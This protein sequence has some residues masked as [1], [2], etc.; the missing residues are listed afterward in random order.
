VPEA[1]L[2]SQLYD[3]LV[4]DLVRPL[5]LLFLTAVSLLA[6]AYRRTWGVPGGRRGLAVVTAM[7]AL[8]AVVSM[9]AGSYL[10][11]GVLEWPYPPLS[12]R[13]AG[14]VAAIVLAGGIV[15]ANAVRR[16][17]E[18]TSATQDRCLSAAELYHSGPRIKLLLSGGGG[19]PTDPGSTEAVLMRDL[20]IRLGV[21]PDDVLIEA[22]SRST[23]ENAAET[24]KA[25]DRMGQTG[26]PVLLVTEAYHMRRSLAVFRKQGLNL[27]PAPCSHRVTDFELH[28]RTFLPSGNAVRNMEL[29]WH[30]WLGI[31]WYALRGYI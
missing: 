18:P 12:E 29:A 25:L 24:R 31:A 10:P 23:F 17:A 11:L 1:A 2:Y 5:P 28:P 19:S 21:D 30:E 3:F 15:P 14:V 6:R 4:W 8:A 26:R 7:T 16:R 22:H 27:I 9:P 20:I 13:P